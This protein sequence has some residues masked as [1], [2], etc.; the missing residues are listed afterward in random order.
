MLTTACQ[1]STGGPLEPVPSAGIE[2]GQDRS[3]ILRDGDII[4]RV[5]ARWSST[6]ENSL[7]I[8]YRNAGQVRRTV[9]IDGLKMTHS[10]GEAALRTAVDA[11][12]VDLAD[13]R[14]DNDRPRVLFALENGTGTPSPLELPPGVSR[15]VDAELTS[16]SND[17]AIQTDDR[18][19]ATIPMG[20]RAAAVIF[21]ARKP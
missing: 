12:G 21:V 13:T 11:T 4:A 19:I 17:G 18:I 20:D 9:A 6:G 5:T 14:T 7:R 10:T 3:A 8:N 15:D 2:A 16:F 1:R